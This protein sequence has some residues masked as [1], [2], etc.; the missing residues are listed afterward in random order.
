M[1]AC[2]LAFF[3]PKRAQQINVKL[4]VWLQSTGS[5]LYETAA[6]GNEMEIHLSKLKTQ[7]LW[8]NTE[9]GAKRVSIGHEPNFFEPALLLLFLNGFIYF[10][11]FW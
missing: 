9:N 3:I 8:R 2:C 10:I 5:P 11:S 4:L 1:D 7:F 6:L